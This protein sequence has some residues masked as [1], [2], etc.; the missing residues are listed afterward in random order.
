MKLQLP[1]VLLCCIACHGV[2]AEEFQSA[3]DDSN[4]IAEVVIASSTDKHQ[5]EIDAGC[6][7]AYQG[8][9]K[10]S[11]TGNRVGSS[12]SFRSS[13]PL[14][15]ATAYLVFLT[16]QVSN[17]DANDRTVDI[18]SG[19]CL[20][21]GI[22]LTVA[23]LQTSGLPSGRELI[24]EHRS[25]YRDVGGQRIAKYYYVLESAIGELV[26]AA[27][28]KSTPLYAPS[29][30]IVSAPPRNRANTAYEVSQFLEIVEGR[31]EK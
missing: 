9:I 21:S 31:I 3:I 22:S 24:F 19:K 11:L 1:S 26:S 5:R 30:E 25:L 16:D 17:S 12:L 6:G 8:S 23:K 2:I 28:N 27:I 20:E 18:Q 4:V 29:D 14:K 13:K 15:I 10:R 7:F